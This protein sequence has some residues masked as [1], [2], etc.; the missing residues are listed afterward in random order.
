MRL[1]GR[2]TGKRPVALQPTWVYKPMH[3]I[4]PQRG[5][6]PAVEPSANAQGSDPPAARGPGRCPSSAPLPLSFPASSLLQPNPP[7]PRLV[8]FLRKRLAMDC[9]GLC[10]RAVAVHSA[11]GVERRA[12]RGPRGLCARGARGR[13]PGS[14][15]RRRRPREGPGAGVRRAYLRQPSPNRTLSVCPCRCPRGP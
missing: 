2:Q 11:F 6:V 8:S 12:N 14:A 10:V 5:K 15:A 1:T 13:R 7:L 4:P 3:P 9:R